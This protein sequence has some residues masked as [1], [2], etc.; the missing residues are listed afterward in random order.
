MIAKSNVRTL[1]PLPALTVSAVYEAMIRIAR[2]KGTGAAKQKQKIVEKLILAAKGEEVR[3]ILRTLARN[4][5]VGAVRT[6]I[7]TCLARA[8][9]LLTTATAPR[10][11][12][13]DSTSHATDELLR[14]INPM[15]GDTKA[16]V[17]KNREI[18]N[19]LFGRAEAALKTVY[20]RHPN[21]HDVVEALLQT[22][23]DNISTVVALTVGM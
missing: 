23:L 19:D 22:G 6:T 5:R 9:V 3:Y 1:Y 4:L 16:S 18:L 21:F 15:Y 13:Q 14:H 8:A 17:D 7:L 10:I 12:G 11:V 2:S 20:A